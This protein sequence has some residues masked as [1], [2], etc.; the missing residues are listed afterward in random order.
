MHN[1]LSQPWRN[2]DAVAGD[3]AESSAPKAAKATAKAEKKTRRKDLLPEADGQ[4][5]DLAVFAA[6]HW[7]EP[8]QTWL[9]IRYTTAGNFLTLA[10]KYQTSIAERMDVG[11]DRPTQALRILQLDTLINDN[12][13]RVKSMLETKYDKKAAPSY[14]LSMGIVKKRQAYIIHRERSKRALA[15]AQLAKGV[16]DQGFITQTLSDGTV[17]FEFGTAFW[18]PIATEYAQL[19]DT[20]TNTTG[21]I[22]DV[23]GTKDKERLDVEKVLR[24]L[25]KI[26]DGNY[27]DAREFNAQLRA[28][29]YQRENYS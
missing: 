18:E 16:R 12:L 10:T 1:S 22:S 25:A 8:E 11:G 13:Y 7:Q 19:L 28:W 29:G 14:F 5:A 20:L 26:L 23:V 17:V 3:G 2:A 9:T 15:L 27:P 6:K 4:L 24:S 21:D